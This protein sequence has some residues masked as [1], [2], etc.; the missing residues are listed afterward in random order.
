[1]SFC[2]NTNQQIALLGHIKHQTSVCLY[3]MVKLNVQEG[4]VHVVFVILPRIAVAD[5]IRFIKT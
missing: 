3:K 1:M 4:H 2:L 5:A